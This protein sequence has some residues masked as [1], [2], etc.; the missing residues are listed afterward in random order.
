MKLD[1]EFRAA[2]EALVSAGGK[3]NSMVGQAKLIMA[4]HDKNLDAADAF[5]KKTGAMK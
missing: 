1:S 5:L 2:C 4:K 3:L